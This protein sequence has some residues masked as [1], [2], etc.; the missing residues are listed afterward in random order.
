MR[1]DGTKNV[2][3]IKGLAL[4]FFRKKAGFYVWAS[5]SVGAVVI[6]LIKWYL[7]GSVSLLIIG[8]HHR[9]YSDA[10]R[11]Q[12]AYEKTIEWYLS[13]HKTLVK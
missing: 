11:C 5:F 10:L 2:S 4:L 1:R 6:T 12:R 3:Q 13:M 9:R 8:R 7:A